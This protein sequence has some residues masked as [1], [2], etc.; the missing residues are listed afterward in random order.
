MVRAK[1]SNPET[2]ETGIITCEEI[3]FGYRLVHAFGIESI[4]GAIN[5][6]DIPYH[7]NGVTFSINFAD[8][9][10]IKSA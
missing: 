1:F 6:I 3:I 8:I 4:T 2:G 7:T 5:I 10:W 9:N